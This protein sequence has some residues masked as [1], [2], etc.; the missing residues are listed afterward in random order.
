M[1]GTG[2]ELHSEDDVSSRAPEFLMITL[3]LDEKWTKGGKSSLRELLNWLHQLSPKSHPK[4][5]RERSE[6]PKKTSELFGRLLG[7]KRRGT[8]W[9]CG[10]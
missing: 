3:Q 9:R 2:V 10:D 6:I 7:Q 4:P 8:V 5:T 1:D